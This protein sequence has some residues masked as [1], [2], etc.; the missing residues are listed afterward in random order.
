MIDVFKARAVENQWENI[1]SD[2]LDVRDLKTLEDG[3]FTHV[4]TNFG[5]TPNV[6]DPSGP[7]KAAREMWRVL[8]SGGVAA[9]TVW[10]GKFSPSS[11]EVVS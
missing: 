2:V 5:F 8:R 11:I 3:T 4:I 9:V 1:E 6:D 7:L 10:S